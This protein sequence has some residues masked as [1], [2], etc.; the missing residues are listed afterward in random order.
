MIPAPDG[1]LQAAREITKA[2][3]RAA[4]ARRGADRPRPA[5]HL[6]RLPADRHRAGRDHAGQGPRRRPAAGRGDRRRRG[7]RPAQARPARHHLRRQPGVLRGRPGRAHAPSPP[8]ACSTTSRRWART[9]RRA[10]RRSRHPL[11]AGVR[12]G[13][14][15]ARHR[16]AAAGRRARSPR[17]RR[18]PATSSTRSRRTPSGSRRRSCSTATRPHGFL[19]ALPNAL[20]IHHEGRRLMPR[21]FLRDDDLSPAEQKAILDLADALKAD[22]LGNKTARR[23]V[24]HRDLREELDPHPVLV[25]GRHQP[26]RRASGD[27]R[28]PLDAARPRRDDRGH[29]AGAVAV[30]RRRSC[31]GP[32]RRSASRRWPRRRRSR[33]STR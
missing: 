33:W 14:A 12:G 6:V 30:R 23:Q 22:P 5:R 13:R 28:R 2:T 32:S 21:H 19:A 1:Y 25:R 24:G 20:D 3:R 17:P 16:V 4:G 18:T 9:S 26:A 8:T 7:R 15:A 10:S 31:G 29:L 11:V 27:R